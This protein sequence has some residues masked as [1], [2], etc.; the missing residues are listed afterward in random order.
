MDHPKTEAGL[1]ARIEALTTLMRNEREERER[2]REER[3]RERELL[4]AEL[5]ELYND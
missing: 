2:E 4:L 3:K 5:S 1:R